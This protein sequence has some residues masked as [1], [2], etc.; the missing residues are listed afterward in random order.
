MPRRSWRR[1]RSFDGARPSA[2]VAAMHRWFTEPTHFPG[3]RSGKINHAG[4][5]SALRCAGP[6][7]RGPAS[8]SVDVVIG[9][10]VHS[11]RADSGRALRSDAASSAASRRRR[12]RPTT[13]SPMPAAR[14]GSARS[15][16]G[17][18][19]AAL[20]IMAGWSLA[21]GT[22]FAFHDDVLTRLIARQAEHAVRLRGPH[23]RAARAGRPHHQPP[24]ARP[25]AVRAEARADHAPAGDARSRARRR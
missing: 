1:P 24:V 21:T 13:P 23:R 16:S 6:G 3:P 9:P 12:A 7:Q 5:K 18:W 19:S 20:V 17:S 14:S 2:A 10:A 22:Y 8:G 25:G 4:L 15:R 11:H